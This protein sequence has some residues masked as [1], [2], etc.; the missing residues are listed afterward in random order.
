M[1]DTKVVILENNALFDSEAR[2]HVTVQCK[3]FRN[4][5][6]FKNKKFFQMNARS[7]YK[8]KSLD[9]CSSSIALVDF[10]Y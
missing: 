9:E 4:R 6:N 10:L 2:Q 3:F 8:A 5:V 7:L 1:F